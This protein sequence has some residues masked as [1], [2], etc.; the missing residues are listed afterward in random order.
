[1]S[2]LFRSAGGSS[3]KGSAMSDSRPGNIT[4]GGQW[5]ALT[6]AFLGWM[7]DGFEMGLFPLIGAPALNDLLNVAQAVDPVKAKEAANQ[8]FAVII[9]VFLVGAATGGVLFGWLGDRIGRV[10]AMALSIL[11]YA[12]FTGF[13]GFATQAWHVAV[14]RFIASLGMGGE[15]ALGVALVI[16]IWPDKSRA[17]LA[18]LIGAA[19][20]VG[21]LLIA[22]ISIVLGSWIEAISGWL[23]SVGMSAQWVEHLFGHSA[24][25]ALMIVG[26]FPALLVFFIRA[27]VPESEKWEH[28]NRRGATSH[29]ANRDLIGVL[30]GTLGAVLVILLW[31]PLVGQ[32]PWASPWVRVPFTL[33]GVAVALVGYIFPVV[34]YLARATT[35]KALDEGDYG[36]MVRRMLLGAGL[37]GVAL[38]GTWGTIQ[39]APKWATELAARETD[40]AAWGVL[41]AH[42]KEFTQ[43]ATGIGAIICTMLAAL[44]GGRF[45]RRVT[46]AVLCFGS[47]AAIFLFYGLNTAIN[48]MFFVAAFVAGGVTAAFYGWFPLYFPELF[49][50]SVRATAQGFAY[51]F[52]R[53]IAAIGTLQTANLT[54]FFNDSFP[55]AAIAMSAIYLVGAGLIWLGPETKGKPLPD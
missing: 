21:F 25:R 42:A 46:Y 10:R 2:L 6:A 17:M 9:A 32:S 18:G 29:W 24:W 34:R 23:L 43:I 35:A 22:I 40:P 38:L 52:G 31:S 4:T 51:N 39:W 28:E 7:F 41:A 44:A 8:W 16:E 12:L 11:T 48:N 27:F 20:N 33:L 19:A 14:L 55:T 3:E 15:W 49:R 26:A 45:G 53:V 50:T 36:S 13:C 47:I 30:I 37:A 54:A 1:M 5:M